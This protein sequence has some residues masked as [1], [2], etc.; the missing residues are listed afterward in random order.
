MRKALLFFILSAP[1]LLS[2]QN[3]SAKFKSVIIDSKDKF[4]FR[5]EGKAVKIFEEEAVSDTIRSGLVVNNDDLRHIWFTKTYFNSFNK[6][7]LQIEIYSTDQAYSHRYV[8]K[9]FK[10]K[11]KV[12]YQYQM[13]G[14]EFERKVIP[15]EY[16]VKLN[17]LDFKKGKTIRGYTEFKGKCRGEGCSDSNI[18]IKGNFKILIE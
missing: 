10:D 3:P 5:D 11:C 2:C 15:I 9:I 18:E 17:S 14:P 4:E 7:T 6:D 12:D 1:Y 13:S 8:I 16:L